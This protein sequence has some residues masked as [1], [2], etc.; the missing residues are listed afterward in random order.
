M[1]VAYAEALQTIHGNPCPWRTVVP[2]NRMEVRN[3]DILRSLAWFCRPDSLAALRDALRDLTGRQN[4]IFA[5][6]GRC[7]IAR[8]LSLLPHEEVVMPAY[9]CDVVKAAVEV[10][11]KRIVYVD[12]AKDSVNAASAAYAE[13]AKPGRVLLV[14]HLFGIPTDIEAICALARERDCV[15]VED[16]AG[17]FGS[18]RNGRMLGT[19][20]DFGVFSFERSKRVSAF[21]GA[22]II[23]NN[24][25]LLDPVQLE[26]SRVTESKRVMPVREII[27]ALVYNAVTLPW[28]YGRFVVPRLVERYRNAPAIKDVSKE[29]AVLTSCYTREFHPYQAELALRV[30]ER[31]NAVR[32]RIASLVS[33]YLSVFRNTAV[34]SLVP[35]E[36]DQA[37]L[38]RFP[39]AVPGKARAEILRLALRHGLYLETNFER[40]LAEE[41]DYATQYPHALWARQNLILLPLYSTLEPPMAELLARKFVEIAT[42]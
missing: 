40:P 4:I 17:A 20:G 7:A 41:S 22:A 3:S 11:G 31:I 23:V 6:S 19:F 38:L 21:R 10:A 37:A 15:V 1:E 33:I 2:L 42:G 35:P 8:I 32:E 5:A 16:A 27:H 14:T 18:R 29:A 12:I 26:A 36:C 39:V 24:D 25:R 9:T 28:F 13:A 34:V 30:I